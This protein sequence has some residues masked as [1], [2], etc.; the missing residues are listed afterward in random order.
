MAEK[1]IEEASVSAHHENPKNANH[2]HDEE[3][4]AE[5]ANIAK[6]EKVYKYVARSPS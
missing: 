4:G 2:S 5:A 1:Q 3:V 6:V